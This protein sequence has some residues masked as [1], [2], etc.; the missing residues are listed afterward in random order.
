[1]IPAETPAMTLRVELFVNDFPKALA[2]YSQVLGF[3]PQSQDTEGYTPVT[4]G[5]VT[6]GL[7]LRA[8]LP[9][10]HPVQAQSGERLGRGVEFVLEVDDIE[11]MYMQI[12][13]TN[14]PI[15]SPLQQQL[16][17]L[18]DFRVTDPDGYYWRI[19]SRV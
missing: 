19:T 2:F 4:N 10:D 9:D 6:I 8:N 17:G 11:T 16:W 7:N 14:W 18:T 1:M 5:R 3:Y 13:A 12:S 15:A